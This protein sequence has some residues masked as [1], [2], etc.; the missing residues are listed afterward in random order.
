[1]N[2]LV[3]DEDSGMVFSTPTLRTSGPS[4]RIPGPEGEA[5]LHARENP[6]SKIQSLLRQRSSIPAQLSLEDK[7]AEEVLGEGCRK[8]LDEESLRMASASI[9]SMGSMTHFTKVCAQDSRSL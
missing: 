5:E 6:R 3:D 7:I 4:M 1:M 8:V 2:N 9:S